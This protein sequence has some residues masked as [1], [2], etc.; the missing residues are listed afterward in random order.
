MIGKPRYCAGIKET[1]RICWIPRSLKEPKP[2][3]ETHG[4]PL[5][6][7]ESS[8]ILRN[9]RMFNEMAQNPPHPTPPHTTQPTPTHY[10]TTL[11]ILTMLTILTI[12]TMLMIL[13]IPTMLTILTMLWGGVG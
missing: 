1:P 6:A 11:T 3:H 2:S 7:R 10:N 5:D 12:L 9:P 13:I 8:R 4:I